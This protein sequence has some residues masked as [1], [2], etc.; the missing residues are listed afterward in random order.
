VRCRKCQYAL[1]NLEGRQCPECGE[2]F[3]PSTYRFAPDS[4]RFLCP[5]CRQQYFGTD[6]AGLPVPRAFACVSCRREIELDQMIVAPIPGVDEDETRGVVVGWLA[7]RELGFWRGLGRTVLDAHIRPLQLAGA[8][9]PDASTRSALG[10]AAVVL[11]I[12]GVVGGALLFVVAM[13][14]VPG[15]YII[16]GS[17]S[18]QSGWVALAALPL[19]G[20]IGVLLVV[21]LLGL[22][23]LLA[24]GVLRLSGR[25]EGG[26][27]GTVQALAYGSG[28]GSLMGIPCLGG[29]FVPVAW[30]WWAI[31]AALMMTGIHKVSPTRAVVATFTP[32]LLLIAVAAAG[33]IG[34][35]VPAIRALP[36][37]SPAAIAAMG[38]PQIATASGNSRELREQ[39]LE[40]RGETGAWPD[41]GLR[42]LLGGDVSPND[43][44]REPPAAMGYAG[45]DLLALRSMPD[46]ERARIVQRLEAALA[47]EV[48][49]TG[50]P[51]GPIVAHRVG[52]A[53]FAYHGMKTVAEGGDAGLWVV[54]MVPVRSPA[55]APATTPAG[56]ASASGPGGT[57]PASGQGSQSMTLS[58]TPAGVSVSSAT[59]GGTGGPGGPGGAGGAGGAG[60]APVEDQVVA[61]PLEGPP[62]IIPVG[63]LSAA[64]RAQNDRRAAAGLPPLDDPR[65]VMEGRPQRAGTP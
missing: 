60:A 2:A 23:A 35:A 16:S 6:G 1:W 5:H 20:V 46:D 51:A 64:L 56:S 49:G 10:F 29:N 28:A 48:A 15:V 18:T 8:L 36:N 55:T 62:V 50:T 26:I 47:A 27:K 41:H 58:V 37:T 45:I 32:P 33:V 38:N 65:D 54:I 14:M 42:L 53:V 59:T 22:W 12:Y 39:L 4:V 40:V 25:A 30:V 13:G 7:R 31:S 43:Y 44:W 9:P 17:G 57:A 52:D 34:W 3:R 21:L 24:H 63:S 61:R 19:G 11:T